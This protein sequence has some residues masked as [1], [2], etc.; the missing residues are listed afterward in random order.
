MSL[1][2]TCIIV[3]ANWERLGV[4]GFS[5]SVGRSIFWQMHF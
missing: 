1:P 3:L 4:T 5:V 2:I